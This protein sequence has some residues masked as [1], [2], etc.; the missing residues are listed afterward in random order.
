MK[1][2]VKKW[3]KKDGYMFLKG[4]GL[5]QGNIILDFGCGEGHYAIPA[6]KVVGGKGKVYALDKDRTALN[7]L[8]KI[9]RKEGFKNIEP[10][11]TEGELKIPL[12][13]ESI[14]VALLYDV[15][16][17]YYNISGPD[18]RKKLLEDVYRVLKPDGFISVYP[19]HLESE[20]IKKE[21]EEAGF[22]L[23]MRSFE[24]LFHDDDYDEGY[25]FN[26]SKVEM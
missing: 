24:K 22:H 7:E 17:P 4:I 25:I 11:K 5:K 19:K 16:H 9:A 20:E 14:D 26:F 15:L 2:D 23:E 1:T 12:E 18:D 10:I 21:A 13:K 3:L 8:K 6:A